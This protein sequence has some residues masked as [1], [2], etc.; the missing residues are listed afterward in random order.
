MPAIVLTTLNARYF[1]SSLGLRCLLANMGELQAETKL[2]EFII[3]QRPIDIVESLLNQRPAIIGFGVYI[4]NVAETLQVVA[5]LKQVQ[6]GILVVLGG[7]EVSYE[8]EGQAIVQ[9]AD[10]VITGPADLG[11]GALCRRL[12][13][14]DKPT[15]KVI[16]SEQPPLTQLALPYRFYT[17]EDIAQRLIYVEA[18]RGCPFRCEFCLSALDKTAWPFGLDSFLAELQALYDRGARQFKFVDRTFNLNSN[19]SLRIMEFFLDRLDATLF[20]HF[21]LIP[22]HLPDS[23][24]R[25]ITRFPPG[26]LQFEIGIQTF[27]PDVQALISRRQDN[28]K[29]AENLIWL[30]SATQAHIHADL[31]VGLPGETVASFAQGFNRLVALNPHEIQVGI[32]KR[33]RGTLINR[34]TGTCGIKYNPCPPY[35]ILCSD[36]IDFGTMQRLNRLARYWDL[37]ANS[38]RF[39]HSKPVLLG[40]DPFARFLGFSDWLFETTQQTHRIALERLFKLVYQGLIRALGVRQ[41]VAA[42]AVSRDYRESGA[43]GCPIFLP[44]EGAR[45][46]QKQTKSPHVAARQARQINN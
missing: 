38:G 1:H 28:Q 43:K 14:N 22:D 5:L 32:L 42:E 44:R 19:T 8:T 41:E 17:A 4:W 7:P 3:T 15:H 45:D 36:L 20:L 34:H 39:P 25:A 29:T 23:L 13:N 6:P 10:Y 24:K 30:R 46:T 18:S 33:L 35:N 21:E 37:I 16:P 27:N 26:S 9:L 2:L 12:L 40:D 31:I 11:F